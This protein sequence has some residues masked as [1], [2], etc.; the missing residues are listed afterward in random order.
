MLFTLYT[1]SKY[2]YADYLY[3]Y[4]KNYNSAGKP[5]VGIGYLETATSLEPNQAIYH[6]ELA[7]S[8]ALYAKTDKKF[9]DLAD[10]ETQKALAISPGNL[11]V[12]RTQFGIYIRLSEVDNNYLTK[13]KTAL[14]KA[15]TMAPNDPK[16]FYNLGLMYARTGQF[17]QAKKILEKTIELKPDYDAPKQALKVIAEEQAKKP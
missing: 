9:A 12:V 16:L 1:I 6:N 8:Y 5:N 11:N 4:G 15:I 7:T 13:A 10:I 17:D 2:W 14:D 3:N